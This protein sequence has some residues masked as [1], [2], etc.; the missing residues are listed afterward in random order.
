MLIVSHQR[1][2]AQRILSRLESTIVSDSLKSAITIVELI[3]DGKILSVLRQ[4]D[5]T[6]TKLQKLQRNMKLDRQSQ[7]KLSI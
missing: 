1:G 3:L 4:L 6:S 7:R 2:E 5:S